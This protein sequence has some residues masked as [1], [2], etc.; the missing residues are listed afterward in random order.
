M[1]DENYLLY[2]AKYYDNPQCIST[3]EFENDLKR[4]HYIKKICSRKTPNDNMQT[5]L[6]LNHI[7]ILSNLFGPEPAARM[8]YLKAR[9]YFGMIR[10]VLEY[11]NM[12]PK[13][14]VDIGN[15]GNAVYGDTFVMNR[16]IVKELEKL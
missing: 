2:A 16:R 13:M 3:E 5:R 14:F 9:N 7:I 8:L 12:M 11:L 1:T 6:L 4:I 15:I 10:P